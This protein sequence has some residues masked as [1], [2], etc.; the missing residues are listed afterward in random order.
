MTATFM[1]NPSINFD[2]QDIPD[3]DVCVSFIPT[4]SFETGSFTS[5]GGW[6]SFER[7]WWES[8]VYFI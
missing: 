6:M 2:M 7:R 8:N 5:V 1:S 4:A 3:L